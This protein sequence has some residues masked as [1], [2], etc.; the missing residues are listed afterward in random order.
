MRGSWLYGACDA[1]QTKGDALD[2]ARPVTRHMAQNCRVII[3][4]AKH[5]AQHTL[6]LCVIN[7]LLRDVQKCF[8]CVPNVSHWSLRDLSLCA[9]LVGQRAGE[10]VFSV[11]VAE[12][13]IRLVITDLVDLAS[14]TDIALIV[15]LGTP[16]HV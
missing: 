2:F 10:S 15:T 14:V 8:P 12:R 7:V 5:R 9:R 1:L 6:K 16:I 4:V 13:S 3:A 11:M